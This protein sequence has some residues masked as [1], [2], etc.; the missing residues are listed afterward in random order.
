MK[1]LA[2]IYGDKIL[3]D[4]DVAEITWTESD[5]AIS[6][7]VALQKSSNVNAAASLIELL[8]STKK[9]SQRQSDANT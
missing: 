8:S 9:N 5:S 2:V 6:L 4:G 7:K 1:H 3:F